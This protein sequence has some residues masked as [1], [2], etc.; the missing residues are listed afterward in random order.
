MMER[1]LLC[2]L[3]WAL[4]VSACGATSTP[5]SRPILADSFFFGLAFEDTNGNGQYDAGDAPVSG[6]IFT[7][8]EGRGASFGATTDASG[9]ATAVIPGGATYPA[10]LRMQPPK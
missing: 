7:V 2:G 1:F 4:A 9:H 5:T 10:T 8:K 6:A 3:V